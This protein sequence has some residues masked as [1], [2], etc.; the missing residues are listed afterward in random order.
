MINF[1]GIRY[2][3]LLGR[4]LRLALRL[5]PDDGVVRLVQGPLRG[6]AGLR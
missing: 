4:A 1:S 5:I 2:S 3:S 6:S